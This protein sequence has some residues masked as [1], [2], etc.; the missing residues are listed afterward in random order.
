MK[1]KMSIFHL[2]DCHNDSLD[3]KRTATPVTMS[4]SVPVGAVIPTDILTE[5]TDTPTKIFQNMETPENCLFDL[6]PRFLN[7]PLLYVNS[8]VK[9]LSASKNKVF[10]SSRNCYPHFESIETPSGISGGRNALCRLSGKSGSK[11]SAGSFVRHNRQTKNQPILSSPTAGEERIARFRT[12][13]QPGNT[14][15]Y[16]S[17]HTRQLRST[18]SRDS[19]VPDNRGAKNRTISLARTILEG[20]IHRFFNYVQS[21]KA[22]A[23][24]SS[25]LNRFN[26]RETK[27]KLNNFMY[28]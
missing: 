7:P 23:A 26:E 22:A 3:D 25:F 27:K 6:Q 21:W 2:S 17:I 15:S 20:R 28:H 12:A 19:F 24:A 9:I 10:G 1:S 18:E 11:E 16:D 8:G 14:E 5:A 13:L 4:H